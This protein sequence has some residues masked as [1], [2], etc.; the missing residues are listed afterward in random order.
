MSTIHWRRLILVIA[1]GAGTAPMLVSAGPAAADGSTTPQATT[2]TT[3]TSG[4]PSTLTVVGDGSVEVTPDLASVDIDV[5]RSAST[6]R[7]ALSD[8][9]TQTDRVVR[10]I[11]RTG[12]PASGIQTTSISTSNTSHE[13]GPKGH[14]HLRRQYTADESVTISMAAK[15]AGSV[16]DAATR[17]GASSV[18]DL[19]FSFVNPNAGLQAATAAAITS[20]QQQAN[21]A[22]A[23]I[24]YVV[25]GVQSINLNPNNSV[26]PSPST[27]TSEASAPSTPGTTTPTTVNPGQQQVTASVQ[28]IY[29]IAPASS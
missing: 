9:N 13:V 10:A 27:G 11:K 1:V 3:T 6:S 5:S 15:L 8:A 17:N 14:R 2:T 28:V 29:T 19:N 4:P 18:N 7:L 21:A 25:T 12:V 20:A 24:G 23:A 26:T 16:I 22:A